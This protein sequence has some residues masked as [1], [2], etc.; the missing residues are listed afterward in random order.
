MKF[1]VLALYLFVS[2]QLFATDHSTILSIKARISPILSI[3]M[4][5]PDA[6]SIVDSNNDLIPS[7]VIGDMLVTSNYASWNMT[8]DSL[9]ELSAGTGRLKLEGGEVYI[10]Y[11]FAVKDGESTIVSQFNTASAP[12]PPTTGSGKSFTLYFYF[13]DDDTVWPQGTYMDTIVL[14]VSTD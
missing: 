6:F 9:Y 10:P 2:T 13:V 5:T 7:K 4:E 14:T 3:E 11:T 8:M 1:I 12:L